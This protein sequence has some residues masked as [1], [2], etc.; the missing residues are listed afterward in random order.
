[1]E[2][3]RRLE[4]EAPAHEIAI[5]QKRP[6]LKSRSHESWKRGQKTDSRRPYRGCWR[7]MAT[8]FQCTKTLDSTEGETCL[9]EFPPWEDANPLVEF[10]LDL[11]ENDLKRLSKER[12]VQM[13]VKLLSDLPPDDITIWTDGSAEEG[14]RNAGGGCVVETLLIGTTL[15]SAAGKHCSSFQAEMNIIE[16]A[17]SY[18]VEL[19]PEHGSSICLMTDSKSEKRSR[20]EFLRKWKELTKISRTEKARN[21]REEVNVNQILTRETSLC[22]ATLA[23]IGAADEP[24]SKDCGKID[25]V[26]HLP[27]RR[28]QETRNSRTRRLPRPF[29]SPHWGPTD[30]TKMVGSVLISASTF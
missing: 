19:R 10:H 4:P 8:E 1:M 15:R 2:H 7:R 20:Q 23:C 25:T 26:D 9:Y 27:K 12:R 5:R 11:A 13:T 30:T 21:R 29:P 14:V 18:T 3:L 22:Q 17:L 28:G 6:R 16:T 24:N